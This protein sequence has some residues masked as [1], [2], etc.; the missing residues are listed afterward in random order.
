[1]AIEQRIRALDADL[2]QLLLAS[3]TDYAIFMLDPSGRVATWNP[4]ARRLK[5][6]EADEIIGRHFS[7]FYPAEDVAAG[8][9]QRELKEAAR[10]GRI[11]DEGWRLRK[12]GSRFW[13]SVVISAIRD[14]DGELIGFAKVTRD[15][16]SRV[17]AETAAR[18][19]GLL[20]DRE[21]IARD[22]HDS[23][24]YNLFA[25]GLRLQAVAG[26]VSDTAVEAHL[27][28]AIDELDDAIRALR[29]Q[30]FRR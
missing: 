11:E 30:I 25:I 4:G 27:N 26:E 14:E 15:L 28:Q 1:M 29:D 18:R 12:D 2:P 13:A 23:V 24:I 22:V 3:V 5:G 6:W 16:T 17:D 8:K 21:R 19:L 9:P 10:E 7:A 20:E